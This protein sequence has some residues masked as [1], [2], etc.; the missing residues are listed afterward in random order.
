M[1]GA[2]IIEPGGRAGSFEIKKASSLFLRE[3]GSRGF[4]HFSILLIYFNKLPLTPQSLFPRPHPFTL[5]SSLFNCSFSRSNIWVRWAYP[6]STFVTRSIIFCSS[7]ACILEASVV[8]CSSAPALTFRRKP[9]LLAPI[10]WRFGVPAPLTSVRGPPGTT[11]LLNIADGGSARL[12]L[13][14]LNRFET[15]GTGGVFR[16]GEED[17]LRGLAEGGPSVRGVGLRRVS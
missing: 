8:R 12:F 4:T 17:I 15:N 10:F 11:A 13:R 6:A 1:L 2:L 14:W 3:G 9:R 5:R 16:Y 7:P